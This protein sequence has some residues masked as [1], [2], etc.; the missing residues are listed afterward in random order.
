MAEVH[1]FIC[2]HVHPNDLIK[3][4]EDGFPIHIIM[5]RSTGKTMD[6]YIEIVN[7]EVAA[8]AYERGFGLVQCKHPKLGQRHVTVEL[9]SM[10][11]LLKDL[12]PRA[13]SIVWDDEA[14]GAPKPVETTDPYSSGFRGF[15]TAEEMAGV[16][17]HAEYP[18]RVCLS[19]VRNTPITNPPSSPPL[20]CAAFSVLMKA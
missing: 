5:E 7:P 2:K 20:P 16:V 15:F 11:A 8:V 9:S 4:H 18:Q 1:Q 3:P 6:C 17:R 12:F 14:F 10:G 13:R 19:P